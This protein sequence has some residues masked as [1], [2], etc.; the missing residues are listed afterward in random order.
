MK[1]LFLILGFTCILPAT[2]L[3]ASGEASVENSIESVDVN[4]S[5]LDNPENSQLEAIFGHETVFQDGSQDRYVLGLHY[6]GL[7]EEDRNGLTI[8][9]EVSGKLAIQKTENGFSVPYMDLTLIPF[10][11]TIGCAPTRPDGICPLGTA[12][13]GKVLAA[14]DTVLGKES[15]QAYVMS[16]NA[17]TNPDSQSLFFGAVILDMLSFGYV[18]YTDTSGKQRPEHLLGSFIK[19]QVEFG[20]RAKLTNT[21][22]LRATGGAFGNLQLP[23]VEGGVWGD[24]RLTFKKRK[25][26][27]TI[28]IYAKPG[29]NALHFRDKVSEITTDTLGNTMVSAKDIGENRVYKY[30]QFGL[31]GTF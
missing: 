29:V 11:G 5:M 12:E 20:I 7:R 8:L 3:L 4:P 19:A 22:S 17:Q 28:S 14:R 31:M 9:L 30:L 23:V 24:F 10:Q 6:K 16:M 1:Y 2:N 26:P 13:V 21:V 15:V 27:Y 25:S 18:N